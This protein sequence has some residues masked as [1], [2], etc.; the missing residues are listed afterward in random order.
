MNPKA[1]IAAHG[2]RRWYERQLVES[3]AYMTTGVL[4]LIMTG[5]AFEMIEFRRTPAG[6]LALVTVVVA[7][8]ALCVFA[9]RRFHFALSLA[10]H[11]AEQAVCPGCGSY[12]RFEVRAAR[13]APEAPAGCTLDARCRACGRE[14][15]IS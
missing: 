7:G 9:W 5:I 13:E 11:L 2:F 14:W 12:A 1:A 4:S 6:L 15:T 3:F 8:G 10:E